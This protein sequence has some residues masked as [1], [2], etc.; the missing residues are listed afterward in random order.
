M[1]GAGHLHP[2]IGQVSDWR[3]TAGVLRALLSRQVRGNAVLE[4]AA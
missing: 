1:T 4:V 3:Q 2:E